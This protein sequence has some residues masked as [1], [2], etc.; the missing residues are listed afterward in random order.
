MITLSMNEASFSQAVKTSHSYHL[1]TIKAARSL[2]LFAA[3][4]QWNS[5]LGLQR[6]ESGG[7]GGSRTG[8][9]ER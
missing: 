6:R 8:Q 3:V 4:G 9:Q 2:Q 1:V 5:R 7:H